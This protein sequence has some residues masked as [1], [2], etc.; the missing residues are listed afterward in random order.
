MNE[1]MKS[2]LERR[3][4]RAYTDQAVP[5]ELLEQILLAGSYA[6]SAK[7]LQPG[8]VVV[9]R[10]REEIARLE[11][12]NAA[13]SSNPD[14]HP[15]YGAPVV[16]VVLAEKSPNAMQDGSLIMG[17]LMLAAHSLGL[18]SCWINRA[19]EELETPEG[20]QLLSAWGLDESY[21]GVGHCILGYPAKIGS[22]APRKPDFTIWR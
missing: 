2:L 5:R 21:V 15:F 18:G 6:P 20:K 1:T 8:K 19:K 4:C 12:M 10:D 11:K 3:S 13:F 7:G 22:P 9:L 17:N 14:G 16:L